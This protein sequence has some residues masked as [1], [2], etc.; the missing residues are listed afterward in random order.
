M[1]SSRRVADDGRDDDPKNPSTRNAMPTRGR[2]LCS[3]CNKIVDGD[4]NHR[5][6]DVGRGTASERLY[7]YKWQKARAK[8]LRDNPWCAVCLTVNR[9][10][11]ATIVDHIKAHRGSEELFWNVHNWQSL[12]KTHHDIKTGTGN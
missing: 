1:W 4:H 9:Y 8:Y 7:N 2:K 5:N 12:C 11:V 6:D 10:T 3:R